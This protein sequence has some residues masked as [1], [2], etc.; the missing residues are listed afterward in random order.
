MML[1]ESDRIIELKMAGLLSWDDHLSFEHNQNLQV[2]KQLPRDNSLR[3]YAVEK[4]FLQLLKICDVT[5]SNSINYDWISVGIAAVGN[6]YLGQFTKNK[7]LS[8][9]AELGVN[10]IFYGHPTGN[11]AGYNSCSFQVFWLGWWTVPLKDLSEILRLSPVLWVG[12]GKSVTADALLNRIFY[13]WVLVRMVDVIWGNL[14]LGRNFPCE[15]EQKVEFVISAA[16]LLKIIFCDC[17]SDKF[18]GL[19]K[20]QFIRLSVI[21]FASKSTRSIENRP[22]V[23]F[24]FTFYHW[25]AIGISSQIKKWWYKHDWIGCWKGW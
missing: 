3:F 12:M 19:V 11:S 7:I 4:V 17:P 13:H 1:H 8:S 5:N 23:Y 14:L 16:K 15:I 22:G 25:R 18:W 20:G 21:G 24:P 6:G 2:E 9:Y 10:T